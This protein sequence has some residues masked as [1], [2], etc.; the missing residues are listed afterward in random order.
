MSRKRQSGARAKCLKADDCF[1]FFNKTGRVATV[2]WRIVVPVPS[3]HF[4]LSVAALGDVGD[5]DRRRGLAP[6]GASQT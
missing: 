6:E 2:A 1:F 5:R 3:Y 4:T